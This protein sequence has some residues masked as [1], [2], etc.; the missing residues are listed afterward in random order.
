MQ[1]LV[2]YNSLHANFIP[3]YS[4]P[5]VNMIVSE[6]TLCWYCNLSKK[7]YRKNI[8]LLDSDNPRFIILELTDNEKNFSL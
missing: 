5:V 8:K 2:F 1:D 4:S 7:I 6:L 3:H